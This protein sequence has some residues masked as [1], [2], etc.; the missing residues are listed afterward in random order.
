MAILLGAAAAGLAWWTGLLTAS[1]AQAA[2]LVGAAAFGGT[3]W[4]GAALLL[5]FFLTSSLLSHYRAR[6]KLM[7]GAVTAKGSRRDA[8]QVAANGGAA[9]ILAV[10]YGLNGARGAIWLAGMV[11]ALAAANADTWATEI[12]VL[13]PVPPRRLTDGRVVLAGTSGGVTVFGVLASLAGAGLIGALGAWLWRLPG[14]LLIGMLA[15]LTG[16]LVDSLLGATYQVVYLCPACGQE[17]EQH[18]RHRCGSATD[19]VRGVAWL[20]NDA[21]NLLAALSGASTAIVLWLAAAG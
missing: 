10:A 1:G 3:G 5:A 19:R 16:S 21:V 7:L 15:G 8:W 4:K 18:P 11:G 12:G 17:T 6:R 2:A 9:A 13:S 20:G 14:L